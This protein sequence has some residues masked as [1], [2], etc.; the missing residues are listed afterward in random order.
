MAALFGESGVDAQAQEQRTSVGRKRVTSLPLLHAKKMQW[1]QLL[2]NGVGRCQVAVR[3][4]PNCICGGTSSADQRDTRN[5]NKCHEERVFDEILTPLVAQELEYWA[6]NF[7]M[8]IKTYVG[9]QGKWFCTS[10]VRLVLRGCAVRSI[11]PLTKVSIR[12]E[13][14]RT[15]ELKPRDNKP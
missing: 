6:H 1:R 15:T 14:R 5:N 8:C 7:S 10:G 12:W 13:I 3:R 2:A 4:A 11:S 9:K